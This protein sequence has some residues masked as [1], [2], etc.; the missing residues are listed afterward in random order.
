MIDPTTIEPCPFCGE[1]PVLEEVYTEV[2]TVTCRN[3]ACLRTVK[4]TIRHLESSAINLWNMRP[5][6]D[7]LRAENARLVARIA[8]LETE[9]DDLRDG[10][11]TS[12][13][14]QRFR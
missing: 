13:S 4:T 3:P 2:W 5:V 12:E 7:E 14:V 9:I 11:N 10:A 8:E 1:V 6:E